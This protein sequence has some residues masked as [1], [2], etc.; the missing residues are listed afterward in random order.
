MNVI[1]H[2][3]LFEV[4]FFLHWL[5]LFQIPFLLFLFFFFSTPDFQV[6]I[7]PIAT[8]HLSLSAHI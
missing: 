5:F 6:G 3:N 7:F 8:V 1:I 2:L 4:F